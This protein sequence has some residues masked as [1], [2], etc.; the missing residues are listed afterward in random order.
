MVG[1]RLSRNTSIGISEMVGIAVNVETR[2]GRI[3][4]VVTSSI[5]PYPLAP[6]PFPILDSTHTDNLCPLVLFLSTAGLT[7]R[8][9]QDRRSYQ[10]M[11][12]DV[13]DRHSDCTLPPT[14]F[15]L[16]PHFAP[17]RK[18]ISVQHRGKGSL[19]QPLRPRLPIA[20]RQQHKPV[21]VPNRSDAWGRDTLRSR[22]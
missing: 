15:I 7:A 4:R 2:R 14:E 17:S 12:P 18:P 20:E 16:I 6:V 8:I 19:S 9:T 22:R 13:L 10:R 21:L 1:R 11:F 3:L 5:V